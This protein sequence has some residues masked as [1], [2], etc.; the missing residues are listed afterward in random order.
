MNVPVVTMV[1]NRAIVLTALFE[2]GEEVGETF[3]PVL[4]DAQS[5][6]IGEVALK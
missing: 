2:A 3:H 1:P 4:F 5:Q 6:G